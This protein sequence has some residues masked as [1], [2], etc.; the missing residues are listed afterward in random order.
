MY[1]FETKKNTQAVRWIFQRGPRLNKSIDLNLHLSSFIFLFYF[2]KDYIVSKIH[3]EKKLVKFESSTSS[4]QIK[5]K[6]QDRTCLQLVT[7]LRQLVSSA[8]RRC[9]SN[10]H[11]RK[12]A[13]YNEFNLQGF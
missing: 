6:M 7:I 3:K 8:E 12:G 4:K 13:P 2:E 5:Y 1:W 11:Q 9:K 10:L